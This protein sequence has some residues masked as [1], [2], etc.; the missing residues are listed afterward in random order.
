MSVGAV[1]GAEDFNQRRGDTLANRKV[2]QQLD[3]G[4]QVGPNRVMPLK[5]IENPVPRLL[6]LLDEGA[7][8]SV[9][10]YQDT[11]V[12]PVEI[13]VVDSMMDAMVR[14]RVQNS[15]EEPDLPNKPGVNPELIDEIHSVHRQKHPRSKADEHQRNVEDPMG[16]PAEPT[17]PYCNGQIIVAA[18]VMDDVEIPKEAR[19]VTDAMEPVVGEVI[20]EKEDRP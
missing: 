2:S 12:V 19:F 15:F 7:E 16:Q 1:G 20:D 10:D 13:F 14:R 4:M 18:R 6:L 17:L 11:T 9:P 5:L 3:P 8:E